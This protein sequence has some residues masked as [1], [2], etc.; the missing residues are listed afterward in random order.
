VDI[1]VVLGAVRVNLAG[2]LFQFAIGIQK[3]IRLVRQF[4][5]G[6]ERNMPIGG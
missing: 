1:C 4:I 6:K 5:T 3:R 2:G